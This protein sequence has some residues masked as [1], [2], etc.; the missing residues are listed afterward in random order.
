MDI[1]SLHR[2]MR[3]SRNMNKKTAY[4]KEKQKGVQKMSPYERYL[5]MDKWY[6]RQYIKMR[7][8]YFFPD[9]LKSIKNLW[10]R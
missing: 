6:K 8:R 5:E 4:H 1:Q 10:K 3:T 7:L 9:L 2:K